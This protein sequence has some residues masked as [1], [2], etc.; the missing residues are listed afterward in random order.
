MRRG[1]GPPPVQAPRTLRVEQPASTATPTRSR[2]NTAPRQ[3]PRSLQTL[4]WFMESI[5]PVHR[6][7]P[8]VAIA[9]RHST[10]TELEYTHHAPRRFHA[11]PDFRGTKSTGSS[12]VRST[13]RAVLSITTRCCCPPA[14]SAGATRRPPTASWS[15]QAWGMASPPAAAMMALRRS[16]GRTLASRHQKSGAGWPPESIAD[17][18]ALCRAIR[19]NAQ[20]STPLVTNGSTPQPDNHNLCRFPAPGPSSPIPLEQQLQH[21]GHHIGLGNGLSEA[22]GQA[23]VFVSLIGQSAVH[24]TVALH[25]LAWP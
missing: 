14:V 24:E 19:A 21:A 12:S 20:W 15:I 10:A 17:S 8:P 3:A 16:L 25:R 1:C 18:R 11:I 4:A 7:L 13:P 2:L 9:V 6:K 5:I 23:G 22:D